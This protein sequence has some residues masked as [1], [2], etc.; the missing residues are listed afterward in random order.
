[1]PR[2]RTTKPAEGNVDVP[3]TRWDTLPHDDLKRRQIM[4]MVNDRRLEVLLALHRGEIKPGEAYQAMT[5]DTKYWHPWARAYA[6]SVGRELARFPPAK[7]P[8]EP[9]HDTRDDV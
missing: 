7:T 4:T 2:L 6:E 3:E 5:Q 9:P 8:V 1:M